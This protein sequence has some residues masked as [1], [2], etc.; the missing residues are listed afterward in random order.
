LNGATNI[1]YSTIVTAMAGN[2]VDF[3]IKVSSLGD[4]WFTAP[5]P[6][7]S[8][9]YW[10]TKWG[11]EDANSWLGDSCVMETIGLGGFAAAA[12]PSVIQL[13]GGSVK[14]AI[15]QTEEMRAICV[16]TNNNFPIPL[17]E[18]E[19]PPVG[20]DIRKVLKTGITPI[21]HGG[22][23]SKEGGNIGA[24]TARVPLECFKKAFYAFVKKYDT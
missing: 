22:I 24:G 2:G 12:A 7:L 23:I 18:F 13:R 3:G 5:A 17:L 16:G 9:K 21:S 6:S 11:P 10:S 8:G 15:Q 20:I 4:E 19:G 14:D 1:E